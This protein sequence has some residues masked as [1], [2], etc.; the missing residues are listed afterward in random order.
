M[1]HRDVF[2]FLALPTLLSWKA[3]IERPVKPPAAAACP[4]LSYFL[5]SEA[6]LPPPRVTLTHLAL[7][8]YERTLG[9]PIFLSISGLAKLGVKTR[10]YR[11]SWRVFASNFPLMIS[12]NS[13]SE[14]ILA[15]SLALGAYFFPL[16][17]LALAF[18]VSLL[19]LFSRQ[20]AVVFLAKVRHLLI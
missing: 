17:C 20:G 12:P 8:S 10:L 11:C 3:F 19:F 1:L 16:C 13:P 14:A 15:C 2:F 9:L 7:C 6:S 5:F 4:P 18:H